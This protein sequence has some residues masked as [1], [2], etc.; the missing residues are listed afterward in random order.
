MR[1]GPLDLAPIIQR[2]EERASALQGVE[3]AGDFEA[4]GDAG[5]PRRAPWAFVM[6]GADRAPR[7]AGVTSGKI[8]QSADCLLGVVVC[9]R[10]LRRADLGTAASEDLVPVL[11]SVRGALIGWTH[12]EARNPFD[13]QSGRHLRF[14]GGYLWW[15]ETYRTDYRIEVTS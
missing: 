1:T 8:I 10:N 11:R 3:I 2:L 4:L 13:L 14:K 9:V 6:L 12:P 15:Q 7:H 5:A